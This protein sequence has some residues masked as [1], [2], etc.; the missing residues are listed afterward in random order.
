MEITV[1]HKDKNGNKPT[2]KK[3]A[4]TR[5]AFTKH[6]AVSGQNFAPRREKLLRT[7]GSFFYYYR[8]LRRGSFYS[9]NCFSMPPDHLYDPTE[10]GQFSNL[11][12]KA[13]ADFLSKRIDHSLFTVSYEAAMRLI[14]IPIKG[15]RPDLIAFPNQSPSIAIEAKGYQNYNVTDGNNGMSQHKKQ[16]KSGP[17][18]CVGQFVACVSYNLYGKEGVKC[19]YYD[20]PNDNFKDDEGLLKKEL[21]KDYYS[22]LL[23]FLEYFRH[24]KIKYGNEEFYEI[25]FFDNEKFYEFFYNEFPP[26]IRHCIQD[27]FE[28]CLRKLKLIL[29]GDIH[30]FAEEGIPNDLKPFIFESMEKEDVNKNI[31]I[32]YDRV[33]LRYD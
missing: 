28:F 13:I 9:D 11:A 25:D 12:G 7:I 5:L 23:T 14:E 32:D 2:T 4:I 8:Y 33:G 1:F 29:P 10:Q 17:I 30:K 26:I 19:K 20:P 31:Y 16:A 24:N 3:Y 27:I 21:S 15:N 22:G 6:M 18:K